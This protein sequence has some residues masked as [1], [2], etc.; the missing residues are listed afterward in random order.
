MHMYVYEFKNK[1]LINLYYVLCQ[2]NI[3]SYIYI[4]AGLGRPQQAVGL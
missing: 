4:C 3:F 1:I 2:C